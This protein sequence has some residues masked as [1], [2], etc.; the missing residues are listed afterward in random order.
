LV[1]FEKH[2]C[3]YATTENMVDYRLTPVNR[4]VFAFPPGMYAKE[5]LV[6]LTGPDGKPH[7]VDLANMPLPRIP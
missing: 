7:A 5:S 1:I 4:H 6:F 2:G 3:L